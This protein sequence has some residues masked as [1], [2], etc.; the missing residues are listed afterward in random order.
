[1]KTRSL[2]FLLCA[3]LVLG[4]AASGVRA[5]PRGSDGGARPRGPNVS[6]AHAG[7]GHPVWIRSG[8]PHPGRHHSGRTRL[9]F[10]FSFGYPFYAYPYYGFYPRYPPPYHPYYAYPPYGPGA[11]AYGGNVGF[12]DLDVAPE[13]AEV[14]MGDWLLGTADDFDGYPDF[15]PLRAGR[16]TI[17]LRHPGYEDMRLRLEVAAGTRIRIRRDMVPLDH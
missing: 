10:G 3:G 5:D 4:V 14:W 13:E 6:Q 11:V 15:L 1:M 9:H 7:R 8:R 2:V 12:V 17:T 16:R